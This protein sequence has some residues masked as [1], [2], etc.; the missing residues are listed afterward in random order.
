MKL[1]LFIYL[2]CTVIVGGVSCV[3]S[4][5]KIEQG[6]M[7]YNKLTPEEERV[8]I[9]KGT[10]APYTG[11]YVN[12]KWAGVYVCRR[13]NAP[14]YNSSDKFDSHCGWPSFDDEIKGA[15]KRVPDADGRRT[16]IICTNCGAHLGHVFLNEGFTAKETRHCVNSISLKF[17]PQENKMIKK[18]YFASGC[19]WGTEYYFMKAKGVA[20]TAVGFMGGHVDHPSYEQVC[21]K[22]TGH[23]ETTEV[24][25][26]TSKTSYEDLVKLFFETHDFTQT[27]GQ[28]P[29]I[30][31]QYLS[32]IFYADENEKNIAE[33][34]ISILQKKGYKVATMLKPLS[35]FWKAED[36]HQQYYEHKGTT[37]YCHVYKKIFE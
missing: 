36:Y 25:Y 13:C 11:E 10:E 12:N 27:N 3:Q 34:Y 4:Q 14:L 15:V 24:D 16:E 35:T 30:G 1:R 8:I 17:I 26:D 7:K 28:G 6:N 2:L 23:L 19:F 33:K 31:P 29:D 37:P 32:C 9:H 18:A 22:N 20:H 5:N 21:Q